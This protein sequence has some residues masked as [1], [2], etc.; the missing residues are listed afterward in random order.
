MSLVGLGV[1]KIGLFSMLQG[2]D[3]KGKFRAY[4]FIRDIAYQ[5]RPCM[6]C[7]GAVVLTTIMFGL[8]N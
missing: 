3:N 4:N 2:E 6:Y 1:L 7:K 8:K 5:V